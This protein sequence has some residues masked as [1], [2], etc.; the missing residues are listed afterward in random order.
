MNTTCYCCYTTTRYQVREKARG[1]VS[2]ERKITL[3]IYCCCVALKRAICNAMGVVD[4]MRDTA[5]QKKK[6]NARLPIYDAV[7]AFTEASMASPPPPYFCYA[8]A[9]RMIDCRQEIRGRSSTAVSSIP[10]PPY[11][12][13][14]YNRVHR[15]KPL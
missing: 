12:T 1:H 13:R 14:Y 7:L 5:V 4:A 8:T 9:P 15:L 6:G 10:L 2:T 3:L 11:T